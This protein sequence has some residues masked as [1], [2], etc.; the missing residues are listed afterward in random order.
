MSRLAMNTKGQ[1]VW[2]NGQCQD[3]IIH[4]SADHSPEEMIQKG[5]EILSDPNFDA[6]NFIKKHTNIPSRLEEIDIKEMLV[7]NDIL[8]R[9]DIEEA[10]EI[11]NNNVFYTTNNKLYYKCP[12]CHHTI[13]NRSHTSTIHIACCKKIDDFKKFLETDP[14][15][16]EIFNFC[17]YK[18]RPKK[19]EKMSYLFDM[20]ISELDGFF[21]DLCKNQKFI[22]YVT[23]RKKDKK[24]TNNEN[25]SIKN[26]ALKPFA[27]TK[28]GFV[29][30]DYSFICKIKYRFCSEV[31][32]NGG[33]I[34]RIELSLITKLFCFYCED[35]IEYLEIVHE[36][37]VGYKNLP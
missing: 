23:L 24:Y 11:V 4:C 20:K 33:R 14:K 6:E 25:D 13:G 29:F 2:C 26:W 15:L 16:I 34:K 21:R 19:L 27:A 12:Y 31:F 7:K 3:H 5:R 1:I 22:N 32:T 36:F 28:S 35:P 9:E 10:F 30:N 17:H 18:V 8:T 37:I